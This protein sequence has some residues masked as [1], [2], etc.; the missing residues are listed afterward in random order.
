M[1][2]NNIFLCESNQPK[3][4]TN[5]CIT[6]GDAAGVDKALLEHLAFQTYIYLL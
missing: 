4:F 3:I 2:L 5:S 6:Y 1:Y